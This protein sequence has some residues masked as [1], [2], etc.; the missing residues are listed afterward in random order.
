MGALDSAGCDP[1][2]VM[3]EYGVGQFEV[4]NGAA[5]GVASADR[6]V[7]LREVIRSVAR[8]RGEK[9]CFAPVMA[10]GKVGNGVHVHFSLQGLDGNSVSYDPEGTSGM[11]RTF[12][13]F[14]AGIQRHMPDMLPLTAASSISYERLQPNRWSAAFNNVSRQDREAG[15]RVC[16]IARDDDPWKS[17][18]VEYRASDATANPYLLL[19][20]LVWA[21]IDGL[22]EGLDTVATSLRDPANQPEAVVAEAG[23]SRLARSLDDALERMKASEAVRRWMGDDFL[24]AYVC[25]KEGELKLLAGLDLAQQ[26]EKYVDCL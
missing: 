17:F 14:V 15:L 2:M 19:G 1:E 5:L 6:A 10:P 23:L 4:T 8:A 16:P 3:P 24:N 7:I 25:H 12:E 22:R 11:S 18:N 9:A 26:V 13:S 21:G 20:A